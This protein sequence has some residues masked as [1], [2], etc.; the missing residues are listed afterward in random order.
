MEFK[1]FPDIKKLSSTQF[2]ITQKIHG[3]NAQIL[4]VPAESTEKDDANKQEIVEK[5]GPGRHDGEWAGPGINSGEG[6]TQ[7][8]LS[9]LIGGNSQKVALFLLKP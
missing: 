6:L 7:K 4:I 8:H 3:T 5:L 2:S 9:S 1:S